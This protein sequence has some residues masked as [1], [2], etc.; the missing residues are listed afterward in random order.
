VNKLVSEAIG[1]TMATEI[2]EGVRRIPVVVRYPE[3]TRNGPASIG[4]LT[5]Q[6]PA[7][8]SVPLNALASITEIDGPSAIDRE[9]AER[10]IVVETNVEGRDVVGFV[11]ELRE[12]IS[13]K[14]PLPQG[15]RI[16]YGGQ[17]E[18]EARAGK[19]L[20]IVLPAVILAIFLILYSTFQNGRQALLILL[21]IPFAFI[22]GI[23]ALFIS[24]SYLSVPASIG[25]I[26]LLGTA[27]MNGVVLVS[28][29]NQLREESGYEIDRATS[30]G[31]ERRFRPVM[32]TAI[33]TVIGLV[34]ILFATGPGSEI[35]KPLAA[36]VVGGTVTSTA[37]T[38]LLLPALY[39]SLETRVARWME[40]KSLR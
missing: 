3:E 14:V 36:V 12:E 22:G 16:D 35:Q 24:G 19:S 32:M 11:N 31:S 40:R 9:D 4:Q 2:I 23:F 26:A 37:L 21:N 28:Y 33:L 29:F 13:K 39:A 15:Y 7:G 25:F 1:G 20:M 18:N 10:N 8:Q 27:V 30:E 5:V 38:L 34:P 17:F 6:S